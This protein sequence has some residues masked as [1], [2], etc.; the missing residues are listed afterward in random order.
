[1]SHPPGTHPDHSGSASHPGGH[2]SHPG[3]HADHVVGFRRRFWWC[4]LLTLPVAATSPM[5]MDWFGYD[6]DFP[7]IEWVGPV[8]GTAIFV[9][10]GGPF[11]S[12]ALDELRS[13]RPGMMLLIAMAIV[14]A[15]SAS[16]ATSLGLFDLE[17]WWELAALITIMLLGHWLEMKALGQAR[18]A[19]TSLAEL[20]PDE[21]ERVRPDGATDTVPLD[22]LQVGDVVLVR[23][24]GRVPA[25]GIVA[26]GAAG[27]DESMVTGESRPVTR[28]AGDRVIAGTVSTDSAVRVRVE[29]VGDD[30]A[31][32]GIQRLVADAQDSRS[33]AQALADRFAALLFYVATGAAVVT[34]VTWTAMGSLDEAVVRSVTVL[35]IACPHAL[36]LAIPLVVSLSTALAARAGILVKDRLALERMRTIEAVLFDKTGTLTRGEHVVTG[37]AGAGAGSR[38][39]GWTTKPCSGWPRRWRPTASTRWRRRSWPRR[40]S[41]AARQS[42]GPR[43]SGRSPGGASRPPWPVSG[44]R[45]AGRPCCGSGSCPSPTPCAASPRGGG[46]GGRPFSTWSRGTRWW[47]PW[48]S[49]TRCDP[50]RRRPWPSCAVWDAGW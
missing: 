33:R 5:V 40:G 4:L 31:L 38:T 48:R 21:A 39:P 32:A 3:N 49:R 23:P 45:S 46:A 11:L 35:V 27:F 25:D 41:A 12:G 14:V 47:A 16:M 10:G 20:L 29:A 28:T 43:I 42:R 7:G 6:L 26:E 13:R 44:W 19:L 24:G 17:F 50:R 30:T 37:I 9:W 18:S 22:S 8:L 36:G 2:A 15:W 34:F 1:M